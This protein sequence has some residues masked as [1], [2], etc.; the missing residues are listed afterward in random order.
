MGQICIISKACRADFDALCRLCRL[1]FQGLSATRFRAHIV[2]FHVA[3]LF[4]QRN[5]RPFP[6]LIVVLNSPGCGSLGRIAQEQPFPVR[7]EPV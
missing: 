6:G 1:G 3:R 7:F 5:A 2:P 4:L